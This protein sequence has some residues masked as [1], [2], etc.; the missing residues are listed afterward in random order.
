[1][2]SNDLS[3]EELLDLV[4]EDPKC[5]PH[6]KEFSIHF[7]KEMDM[8]KAYAG[9]RGLMTGLIR[10]NQ[11]EVTHVSIYTDEG[12]VKKVEM[13]HLA[14]EINTETDV[15]IGV[16]ALVPLG[17]LKIQK[18]KRKSGTFGTIIST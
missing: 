2:A 8:A 14:E 11:A 16:F 10:N 18:N 6:E 3:Q 17:S 12:M 9:I 15:I 4:K 13:D 7:S 5:K 1:M